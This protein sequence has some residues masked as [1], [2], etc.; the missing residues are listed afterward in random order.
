MLFW[1][2]LFSSRFVFSNGQLGTR[3]P[4][5]DN[6]IE[7]G[8]VS[9]GQSGIFQ[10]GVSHDYVAKHVEQSA[11]TPT[12]TRRQFPMPGVEKFMY[13]FD[14]VSSKNAVSSAIGG[15]ASI[16][17]NVMSFLKISGNGEVQIT[18]DSVQ[19]S[20]SAVYFVEHLTQRR[21]LS[22]GELHT[23]EI[24]LEQGLYDRV[25]TS[26]WS[27][28]RLKAIIKMEMSE[29]SSSKHISAEAKAKFL[30]IPL[31]LSG[32]IKVDEMDSDQSMKL[33]ITYEAD[34]G[35][36]PK[37]ALGDLTTLNRSVAQWMA[38]HLLSVPTDLYYEATSLVGYN[39][40]HHCK[41]P[42]LID[43]LL[44]RVTHIAGLLNYI[45]FENK[46]IE[47][48]S[49]TGVLP[50]PSDLAYGN[51]DDLISDLTHLEMI[52]NDRLQEG[53]N[54][55]EEFGKTGII[56][57]KLRDF[58]ER[59]KAMSTDFFILLNID[60]T[61]TQLDGVCSR[62]ISG[63]VISNVLRTIEDLTPSS[64]CH[65]IWIPF[66]ASED[67][68]DYED[69]VSAGAYDDGESYVLT[70][71]IEGSTVGGTLFPGSK[72]GGQVCYRHTG[73]S[74]YFDG[75]TNLLQCKGA[76]WVPSTAVTSKADGPTGAIGFPYTHI[77]DGT[78][79]KS[80]VVRALTAR[81]FVS[82]F[83]APCAGLFLPTNEDAGKCVSP[84]PFEY[85]V[86]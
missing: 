83:F 51:Y 31:A 76:K 33:S 68:S 78:T 81:G 52:L 74:R 80:F 29:K 3:N 84:G 6:A 64:P 85:L 66:S 4:I 65:P 16:S 42:P 40:F 34:G 46:R 24:P 41:A 44:D 57:D 36:S 22:I 48:Y 9:L 11:A 47:A 7:L 56:T 49:Q 15:S 58:C 14:V 19:T 10:E 45:H 59:T 67:I 61:D 8:Y 72:T 77:P 82:G 63:Q 5:L 53:I 50:F 54:F 28:Y 32:S 86:A 69:I 30:N 37:T 71:S 38:T 73:K 21:D 12:D 62:A 2:I 23:A 55:M 26:V 25:V 43:V 39:D 35:P 18:Q 20:I 27:G 79:C 17:A 60:T 1:L 13:S 70:G 75:V